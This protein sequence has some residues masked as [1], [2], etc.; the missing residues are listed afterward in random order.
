MH[1][2]GVVGRAYVT[3]VH[4]FHSTAIDNYAMH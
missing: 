1:P 2:S 4:K 3:A